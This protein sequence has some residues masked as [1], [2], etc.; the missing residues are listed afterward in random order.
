M[1]ED[2][3][4]LKYI[5]ISFYKFYK[6]LLKVM[7]IYLIHDNGGRPFKVEINKNNVIIY[8]KIN[9]ELDEYSEYPILYFTPK[10]VFIGRC[11]SYGIVGNGNSILLCL[12]DNVNIFIG[13]E[14]FRFNSLSEIVKFESPI[15]NNDVPYPYAV[16]KNNNNYLMIEDV[17]IKYVPDNMD[18]YD[19][20]YTKS[21]INNFKKIKKYTIDENNYQLKYRSRPEK[22]YIRI[23]K[24]DNFGSG[25]KIIFDNDIVEELT[26]EKYTNLLKDYGKLYGF[27]YLPKKKILCKRLY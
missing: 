9:S 2:Y 11:D 15:G 7:S 4:K 20:Y 14:I 5:L 16:D 12:D 23:S 17:L 27:S 21:N 10:K 1:D 24:W 26:K 19:F 8:K 25:M 22:D 6:I 3:L 13:L 18:P